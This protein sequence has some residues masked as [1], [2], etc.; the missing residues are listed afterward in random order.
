MELAAIW[1]IYHG[2][3]F[4]SLNSLINDNKQVNFVINYRETFYNVRF[5]TAIVYLISHLKGF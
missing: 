4:E 5:Y 1:A 3:N 2:Q